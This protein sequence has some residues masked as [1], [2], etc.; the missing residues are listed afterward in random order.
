MQVYCYE[1]E[2]RAY[3]LFKRITAEELESI[4]EIKRD[5]IAVPAGGEIIRTGDENRISIRCMPAG[6]FGIRCWRTA[7]GRF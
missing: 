1:C 6:P 3:G 2:L 7:A 4:R 5:H